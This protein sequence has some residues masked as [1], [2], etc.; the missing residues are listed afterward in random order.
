MRSLGRLIKLTTLKFSFRLRNSTTS[1][2]IIFS[3]ERDCLS[4]WYFVLGP[5]GFL[6]PVEVQAGVN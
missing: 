3:G 1:M 6:S 4:T 5:F 2:L